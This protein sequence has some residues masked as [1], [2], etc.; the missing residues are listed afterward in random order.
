MAAPDVA[1]YH[2]NPLVLSQLAECG[3]PDEA[4][5]VACTTWETSSLPEH[6]ADELE[7]YTGGVIVPSTFCGEI[8]DLADLKAHVVPHCFDEG[9]WV[10]PPAYSTAL[11]NDP[12]ERYRFYAIGASGERKNMMGVLKAYL[13][14]FTAHDRVH[15]MLL[16]G[17]PDFDEIRSVMARSG[18]PQEAMPAISIPDGVS[19]NDQELLELHGAADCF[20]SATRGEGWGLGL[21]EAAIM[22]RHVIAPMWGGQMDFLADYAW[23]RAVPFGLTP[24]FGSEIKGEIVERGGRMMQSSKVVLPPGV[25]CRQQWAEPSLA[26]LGSDMRY[27]YELHDDITPEQM[28]AERA[29]LEARFGYKT[30]GPQL[31]KLLKEIAS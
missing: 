28:R 16:M 30:V 4:V 9:F 10:Q 12:N 2:A 11:R 8:M 1:I 15:L 17:N 31:A 27:L 3:L 20:V 25:N 23:S 24:C 7:A 5:R 22:G 21:F 13:G 14:E 29:A 26:D 18:L 6:Y 19:M